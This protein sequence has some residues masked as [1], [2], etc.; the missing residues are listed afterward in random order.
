MT[1]EYV[2]EIFI[3]NLSYYIFNIYI[4]SDIT[5]NFFKPVCLIRLLLLLRKKK[6]I[7]SLGMS[8]LMHENYSF[9]I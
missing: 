7:V 9:F 2:Y 6:P 4:C 3:P 8:Q 1:Y 5:I